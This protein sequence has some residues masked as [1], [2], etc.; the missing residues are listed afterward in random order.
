MSTKVLLASGDERTLERYT[1]ILAEA[2]GITLAQVVRDA[3]AI[4]DALLRFPDVDVL[5]ID[6]QLDGGRGLVVARSIGAA[7]PLL[8]LVMLVDQTGP[9]QLAAAMDSGARSVISRA[10]S[11]AEVVARLEAVAQWVG[12][13]RSAVTSDATG[14][15]GGTVIAVAGAK[16]GVGTSALTL[17]LAQSYAG[18]RTVGVVDFDL[19]SGDLAAYLGVHT[20]RSVVDLVDIAGEMT[21]RILRETSYDVPGGVRLLSAPNDGERE[22]EM[23]ARAARSIVNALRFQFDVSVIDVGSHLTEATAAVLEEA[24]TTLLVVT[25][26]LPALRSARRTLAMWERLV[27]RQRSAVQVVLNR[28]NRRNE[29][30]E[31]LAAKIV[32]TPI[33]AVVPDGGTAFESAMNTATVT[34]ATGPAHVAAGR[35][36]ARL[37]ERAGD[38]GTV[39][40]AVDEALAEAR[41]GGRRARRGDAGQAAVDLPIAFGVALL[42]LLAC[43]QGLAWG[44]GHLVA[45]NAAHEAARTAGLLPWGPAAQDQARRDGIDRLDPMWRD[46]AVV[47]VGEHDVRV[48]VGTPS[49]VP[50][51]D[52]SA[53]VSVPVQRER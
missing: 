3:S 48:S 14:G 19:Q 43:F 21:G 9:D 18:P 28:Q 47:A 38:G 23:T 20:R 40:E 22:E 44:A 37:L 27:V 53:A 16:G 15:R 17:L 33:H 42:L 31:Q 2:E 30:T 29:V 10:S 12:A 25:P 49:L 36:G 24:D 52:M 8:G 45:R 6:D 7:N 46:G 32:E 13:A 4:P 26:D 39:E 50:G 5:V 41:S 1:Q 11:L 34:Q 35:L 51:L